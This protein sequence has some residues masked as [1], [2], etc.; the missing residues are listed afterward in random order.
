MLKIDLDQVGELVQVEM[1]RMEEVLA[2]DARA[3][4]E[5]RKSAAVLDRK[6][7][8]VMCL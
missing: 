3:R 7:L 4:A 8:C 1:K 2:A 6:F 5:L